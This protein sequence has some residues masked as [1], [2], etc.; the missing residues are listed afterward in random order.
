[1]HETSTV[2]LGMLVLVALVDGLSFL[3][4]RLFN[5]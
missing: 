5:R 1:M 2:L 3:A 4:R